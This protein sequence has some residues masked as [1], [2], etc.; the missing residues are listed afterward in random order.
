MRACIFLLLAAS[1][2]ADDLTNR[3]AARLS[4]EAEAFLKIAPQVLGTEKLHQS[5]V[6]PPSRFHPRAGT[7][8]PPDQWVEH[9]IIS[10]YG[11]SVFASES[12]AIHELRKVTSADGKKVSDSKK[13]QE[14]LARAMTATDDQSKKELLKQFEHYGLSGA[15]NDFGQLLLLFTRRGIERYEFTARGA[16]MMG[17]DKALVFSFKQI[18]GPE[19]LTVFNERKHD[20]ASKMK[21]EGEIRVRAD[22]LLPLQITLAGHQGAIPN[23]LRE[24]AAVTYKMSRFGALLPESTEHQESRNG[25]IVAQ[26]KFTYTD[27]HMF[28][29]SSGIKFETK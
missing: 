21:L 5:A 1:L 6:K 10:E 4:E 22:D 23:L 11:F 29:A 25:K 26:N 20:E 17:Y 12:G 15:V 16:T 18:D 13:A 9:D 8:P 7:A 3:M 27:F 2:R 14:E 19:S 24:D 28:G